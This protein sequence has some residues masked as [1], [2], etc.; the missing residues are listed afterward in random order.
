M[1][2][3]SITSQGQISIPVKMRRIFN[4]QSTNK[5]TVVSTDDG[6]LIKPVVDFLKLSG[7][8][9]TKKKPLTSSMI[10]ESFSESMAKRK[11][12]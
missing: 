11:A 12:R 4:L 3:V 10:H 6:I 8:F 1:Y 9:T 7:S 5:A 2:T